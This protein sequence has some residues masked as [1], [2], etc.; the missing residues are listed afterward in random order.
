M[1]RQKSFDIDTARREI[2]QLFRRKG[3][4]TTSMK[5]IESVTGLLPGSLY[6][7]FGSKQE[8]FQSALD[9]Y[10]QDVVDR[11][12]ATHLSGD[13]P[14]AGVRSLFTST[15]EPGLGEHRGCLLTNTAV[16]IGMHDDDS[17]ARVAAGIRRFEAAFL[18]LIRRGQGAGH[19]ALDKDA[20]QLARQ[21]TVSYQ[22]ILVLVKLVKTPR[23]L[24]RYT[25]SALSVLAS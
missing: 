12:I 15:Y 6:N 24:D 4:A 8:L 10:L 17:S 18:R 25:D 21:L 2:S 13:D 14:V 20:S 19:V 5:D 7:A 1:T 16:E 9:Y 11:R 23:V 3:Y 22:G